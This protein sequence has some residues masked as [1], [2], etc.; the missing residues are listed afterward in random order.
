[1][2]GPVSTDKEYEIVEAWHEIPTDRVNKRTQLGQTITLGT[3]HGW[4]VRVA[5]TVVREKERTLKNG[6]V[7]PGSTDEYFWIG[8]AKPGK[9][10]LINKFYM[11]AGNNHVT[12]P[13]LKKYIL[14][15]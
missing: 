10:F 7:K 3:K 1:M 4:D 13:E 6:K 5:R 2:R 8:G 15:N 14:E 9:V 11:K 12:F